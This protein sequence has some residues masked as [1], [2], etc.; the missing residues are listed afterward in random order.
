MAV[1]VVKPGH[2]A[3]NRVPSPALAPQISGVNDRH[4]NALAVDTVHLLGHYRL[5][6]CQRPPGQRHVAV[7]SGSELVNHRRSQQKPMARS[8]RPGGHVPH[9]PA[10]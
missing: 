6:F 3:A 9:G 1:A 2:L 8:G 5:D 7:D 10:E 4:S